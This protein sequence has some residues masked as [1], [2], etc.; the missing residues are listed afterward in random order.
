MEVLRSITIEEPKT[1]EFES[2]SLLPAINLNLLIDAEFYTGGWWCEKNGKLCCVKDYKIFTTTEDS[3]L[4]SPPSNYY[5][6]PAL[7][8]KDMGGC[9]PGDIFRIGWFKFRIISEE[10]ALCLQD[11]GLST[12]DTIGNPYEGSYSEEV[13]NKWFKLIQDLNQMK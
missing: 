3:D 2:A 5:I 12:F 8:I 9:K 11:I 7:K 6:R 1:I 13:V 10:Y 4:Y